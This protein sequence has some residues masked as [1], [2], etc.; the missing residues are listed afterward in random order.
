MTRETD[1][2]IEYRMFNCG[3]FRDAKHQEH[4]EADQRDLETSE[5]K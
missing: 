2:E 3:Q 1:D 4:Y 5:D